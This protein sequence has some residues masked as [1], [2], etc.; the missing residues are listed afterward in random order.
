MLQDAAAATATAAAAAA[1]ATAAKACEWLTEPA[2]SDKRLPPRRQ[3][4]KAQK[5]KPVSCL[6]Q[7]DSV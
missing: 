3:K 5:A 7:L 1:A 6:S 4:G 2:A